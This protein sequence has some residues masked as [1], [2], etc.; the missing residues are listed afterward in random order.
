MVDGIMVGKNEREGEESRS[1]RALGSW[2][3]DINLFRNGAP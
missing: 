1:H 2:E 3:N